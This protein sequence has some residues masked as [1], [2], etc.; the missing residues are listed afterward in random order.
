MAVPFRQ[1]GQVLVEE[2]L[3][4]TP[5]YLTLRFTSYHRIERKSAN[6]HR[7][8][9]GMLQLWHLVQDVSDKPT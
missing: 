1:V 7:Q 8:F 5:A 2:L 6:L 9:S 4:S 3:F